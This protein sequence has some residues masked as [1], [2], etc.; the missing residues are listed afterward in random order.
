MRMCQ[1]VFAPPAFHTGAHP[2]S[3][4]RE[5]SGR[6]ATQRHEGSCRCSPSTQSARDGLV[7]RPTAEE[8]GPADLFYNETEARSTRTRRV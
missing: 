3:W 8:T 4:S 7:I 5:V 6:P 1:R 2:A